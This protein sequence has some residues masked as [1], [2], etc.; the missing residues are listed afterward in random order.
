MIPR[1]YPPVG[2]HF[3]VSITGKS[4][5]LEKAMDSQFQSVSGLT[6]DIELEEYAEGGENRFNHKLPVKTKFPNLVLTRGLL[7]K[8]DLTDWC[9]GAIENFQ[10]ELKD[11]TL[12]LLNA[13]HAPLMAWEV[14][15]AMPVKWSISDLN[16]EESSIAVES[17]EL[18]Y[19][20]FTIKS[21]AE[22]AN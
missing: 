3:V 10:F 21:I 9:R 2:F 13:A 7:V 1:Y 11:L 8:S 12:I 19:K 18:A 14:K 16:A 17:I 22:Y 15:G 4:G 5:K 20:Y 6:V